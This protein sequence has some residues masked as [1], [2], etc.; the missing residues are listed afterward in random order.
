MVQPTLE[1]IGIITERD[2]GQL[3]GHA[4]LFHARVG[5]DKANFVD[6]DSSRIRK[7]RLQLQ[8][9]LGRLGLDG[10][11]SASEAV[12]IVFGDGGEEL[13]PA[14]AGRRKQLRKLIY[15]RATFNGAAINIHTLSRGTYTHTR[16]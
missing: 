4:R 14:E 3:R 16:I 12:Q 7:N 1:L 10:R 5:G 11:E 13:H 8:R 15:N 6:A 2:R 9:E